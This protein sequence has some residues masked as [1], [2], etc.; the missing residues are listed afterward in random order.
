[1]APNEGGDDRAQIARIRAAWAAYD[2]TGDVDAIADYLAED[3]V[4]MPPGTP[5][6]VGKAAVVEGLTDDRHYDIDQRSEDLF[7]SGAL[8]VDRVTITGTRAPTG[9]D[10]VSEVS[11]KAVDVYRRDDDGDWKCVISIWND[12]I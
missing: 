7:V 3:V 9:D 11:A 10:S 4:L 1:M 5:P 6:I 8:A 12:Q 2:S